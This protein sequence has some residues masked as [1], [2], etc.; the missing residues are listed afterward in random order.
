MITQLR[1]LSL[2]LSPS[3]SPFTLRL[4]IHVYISQTK[5]NN[6]ENIQLKKV[7]NYLS[8][9]LEVLYIWIYI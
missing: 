6:E 3:L 7:A 1:S 2:S 5:E 4:Y 9:F 8:I